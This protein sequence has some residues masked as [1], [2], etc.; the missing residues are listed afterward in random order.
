MQVC[1]YNQVIYIKYMVDT[2][3][4]VITWYEVK[5]ILLNLTK[6]VV[7][8]MYVVITWYVVIQM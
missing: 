4:V 6:Y 7:D 5:Q 1:G 8:T 3:Y 2:M